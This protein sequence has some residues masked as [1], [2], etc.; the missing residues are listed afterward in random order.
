MLFNYDE[1]KRSEFT[2]LN[3]MKIWKDALL[4]SI[5]VKTNNQLFRKYDITHLED[6]TTGYEK[7]VKI[8]EYNSLLEAANP[9]LFEYKST[10]NTNYSTEVLKLYNNTDINPS[11]GISSGDF[12]GD[13]YV[14]FMN[15]GKIY[16]KLF[17]SNNVLTNGVPINGYSFLPITTLSLDNKLNQF[18]SY[19]DINRLN[20]FNLTITAK[21]LESTTNSIVTD[22]SKTIDFPNHSFCDSSCPNDPCTSLYEAR[23][24]SLKTFEGDFN[25]DGI[26]ELLILGYPE[27]KTKQQIINNRIPDPNGNCTTTVT[28]GDYPNYARILDLNPFSSTVL[29]TKGYVNIST[30]LPILRDGKTILMDFNGDGKTDILN[31]KDDKTYSIIGFK[32]LN[33]FPWIESEVLGSG[34]LTDYEKTKIVL[35]GDF[36]GDG[37]TDLIIPVAKKNSDWVIYYANPKAVGTNEFFETERHTIFE[38]NPD[39]GTPNTPGAEYTTQQHFKNY[40]TLD[41]NKDGKSDIVMFAVAHAK[42]EWWQYRD[43]DTKWEVFVFE[44]NIGRNTTGSKF[45]LAYQSPSNH[46]NDSPWIPIPLVSNFKVNGANKDFVVLRK[47]EQHQAGQ[48]TFI[49]FQKNVQEDLLLTK[50]NSSNNIVQDVIEYKALEP[51]NNINNGLGTFDEFYSS[52]NS[53]T[54]PLV[55]IKKIPTSNV[56]S[57]LTNTT[58]GVVKKQ[59]YGYHGFVANINGLGFIGFNKTARSSWFQNDNAEKI[60]SVSEIYPELRGA[61]KR[62]YSQLVTSGN[63]FAF[64]NATYPSNLISLLTNEFN[65]ISPN[66]PYTV[67]LGKQTSIDYLTNIKNEI[68][69]NYSTDGFYIPNLVTSKNYLSNTLQ[70]TSTTTTTYVNNV[71]GGGNTYYIGRPIVV[72]NTINAYNDT[73]KTTEKYFYELNKLKRVEKKGNSLDQNYLIEEYDYTPVGNVWKITQKAT[74]GIFPPLAARSTEQTFDAT[75]RFVISSKDVE[76]LITTKTFDPL[77]GQL[78]TQTSPYGLTT[79][80]EYDSWG[81]LKKTTDYLGKNIQFTYTKENNLF[82]TAVAGQ[83]GSASYKLTDVLG[84]TVRTGVKNVDDNWSYQAI[85]YDFLGRKFKV[86]DPSAGFSTYNWNTNNYDVYNRLTSINYVSGLTV[87]MTHNGVTTT[88]TD[89]T[90][91]TSSTKDSNGNVVQ[92]T[93]P[94]GTIY[95]TYFANGSLKTSNFENTTLTMQYDSF[96]R[97][98]YLNDPS[99]GTYTYAYNFYGELTQETTPKG[100]TNYTYDDV[101]KIT[102]KHITGSTASEATNILTVYNYDGNKLLTSEAITNP[103]DGNSSYTYDYDQFKRLWKTVEYQPSAQ[104]KK[105]YQF[106]AFG[107]IYKELFHATEM[108]TGKSSSKMIK[109]NYKNGSIWQ[110]VDDSNNKILWSTNTVNARGQLTGGTF[111]NDLIQANFY[112]DNGLPTTFNTLKIVPTARLNSNK[113]DPNDPDPNDPIEIDPIDP[114]ETETVINLQYNFNQERALLMNRSTNLFNNYRESFQYDTLERLIEWGAASEEVHNINFSG[115]TGGFSGILGAT[116]TSFISKLRVTATQPNSGAQKLLFSN[117]ALGTKINISAIVNKQ[118]TNKINVVLVEKDPTSTANIETVLGEANEGLFT[119]DYTINTYKDVYIKFVKSPTS[120]DVGLSKVFAVDDFI[121]TKFNRQYQQYDNKGRITQSGIGNYAYDVSGKAYQNSGVTLSPAG[122]E[123][124]TQYDRQ[125]ITYNAFKSPVSIY[126]KNYDRINFSYNARENRSTMFY[127]GL[128]TDK[129]QRTYRKHYSSDGSFEIKHNTV[130]GDVEFVTYIGGDGYSAPI[131]L[132]SDGITQKYLYLHRD[133]LGSII[134]ISNETGDLIEKR[135]FDAWGNILKIQDA[136]NNNISN[137]VVL[138]R[139]YTGHEHLQSVGLIHMNGRLYDPVV[140]RFLQPDNFIQDPHN[141]Q[142]YNRYGYVLN[143]PLKYTDPSG[144]E[145]LT[146]VAIGV[147]VGIAAYILNAIAVEAPINFQG[148]LQTTMMSLI[149]TTLT[150]GVGSA[151]A[152]ISNFFLR[153]SV[154]AVAHGTLQGGLSEFNGDKFING[155]ASGSISSLASSAFSGGTNLDAKGNVLEG[156]GWGGAGKFASSGVGL[157]SFGTISGGLGAKLTGGNFWA[158]A[159]T[160]FTVSAFNHLAHEIEQKEFKEFLKEYYAI[161]AGES[162]NSTVEAQGIGEVILRRMKLVKAEYKSNFIEKIG[163]KDQFDAIGSKTYNEIKSMSLKQIESL[164]RNDNYFSRVEGAKNAFFTNNS[165][166]SNG[167]YFWNASNPKTGFNWRTFSRGTFEITATLGKTTFFK[168]SN[169][170]KQ[171]P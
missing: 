87:T 27:Q 165:N 48:I 143:N 65:T 168:Y 33:A 42:A 104:Y 25:G 142:N 41:T 131:V 167:A 132:K 55:E 60:W 140:H 50:V 96:G 62:S 82:K 13:G 92:A 71:S 2:Y 170:T 80:N 107:R 9:I 166:V 160:G 106:D 32:Q 161:V 38:Y 100:V 114:S 51:S 159:A 150:F 93:D 99:A 169:N 7:V 75:G 83:D 119:A 153:A 15:E 14:D 138:D 88:S 171:W 109:N 155:F 56:V 8:Q 98:T 68:I 101:G 76:G 57:K 154:Q 35:F 74:P 44:N 129:W 156:T 115:T 158:G 22:Y 116:V 45:P 81:K 16:T 73:F 46:A 40:Y 89:G 144:E 118:S 110:K 133:Y 78:L 105:E 126:E 37:K 12:D 53:V 157:V 5:E 21:H 79:T 58:D 162:S 117:I 113:I 18:Q 11:S 136:A 36:N 152:G 139:G 95:Y 125:E 34:I 108:S 39:T 52:T 102:S 6:T 64:T 149:S 4:K 146:M 122:K 130:S 66:S 26:S 31:I 69:Y 163:G 29:G 28:I 111:G 59:L 151:T 1:A 147:G 24:Q 61:N 72:E 67:L 94:G 84:R 3:G 127:G 148:V 23:T 63:S 47:N 134:A 49:D 91:T 30:N 20:L 121:V 43:F 70:S 86:S 141:T 137:L 10:P 123:Y 135:H 164:S 120:S 19:V 97:K 145:F 90:K 103:N 77:Y 124:Y 54:Y 85:Q 128:Q 17:Q 112:S